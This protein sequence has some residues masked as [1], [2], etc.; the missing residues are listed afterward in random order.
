MHYRVLML[1]NVAV[2][3]SIANSRNHFGGDISL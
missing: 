3:G 2:D 1:A